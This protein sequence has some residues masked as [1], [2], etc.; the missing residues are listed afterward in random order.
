M[1][2]IT[3]KRLAKRKRRI[4]YRLRKVQW[5]D[6][7]APMF[8]ASN[9]RYEL[10][11]RSSGIA[12]GGIGLAHML[13]R[14]TG[15]IKAL[16]RNLHLLKLHLPYWESD[17]VLNIAYNI[18]AGGTCI[19]DLELLRNDKNYLD[20]L[21]ARRI[22]DPTTAG[23]FCRRFEPADVETLMDTYNEIRLG[24]WKQQPQ[25]F[26]DEAV[27]DADGVIAETTGEC[28]EGMDLAYNGKW[29]YHP[30]VVSL[31]NTGEPIFLVNR[32]G[33]RPSY[34]GASQRL[35]QSLELFRRAGF[36]NILFR[37]DTDFSQTK[38]LDRWDAAGARFIFGIPAMGNLTKLAESLDS[39]AW[40]PLGRKP[41]YTVR[42]QPRRR[43]R[44]VK[45][46]IVIE[47]EYKNIRL[48]SEQV[49]EFTYRPTACKKTYRIVVVRKN[50]S[51]ER[52]E[53]KL[54]DEARYFFYIT[55]DERK[56]A[57]QI[58]ASANQRCD[59]ENLNAQLL[60]GV[61]AMRMPVDNLVSNW[62]YMVMAAQA[63]TMKA[64]LALL[65]PAKGRWRKK[66]KAEKQAVLRME[67]K[68]FL[69]AFMRLP[70]QIIRTSRRIVYRLLSW[71][72]WQHVF[73]R[74]VDAV[75]YPLRC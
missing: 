50:L 26:F 15:L 45:E 47:R 35:D 28:K 58:V 23:D 69:N 29:G 51:V 67:F 24:V 36:R 22:P 1:N 66:H 61:R 53:R 4:Q 54:F 49:A 46:A 34:E 75:R 42:T 8:S 65:L 60:N 73:L 48:C 57:E 59:Q 33:N 2:K 12:C 43:P 21:G 18:L 10:A 25:E 64:W 63:W 62:A 19:E 3:R 40:K 32:S 30:L 68:T 31:A 6:Q 55:N 13:T 17:H 41:R 71:N 14:Q 52:G 16:D 70:C 11:D 37:G 27:I 38:H 39:T 20:A 74:A 44:N 72:R 7:P 5:E 9:I 56:S